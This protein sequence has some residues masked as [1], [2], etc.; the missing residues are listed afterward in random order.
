MIDQAEKIT[1]LNAVKGA[2]LSILVTLI[3]NYPRG[4]MPAELINWTGWGKNTISQGVSKLEAMALVWREN[5]QG[6][7]RLTDGVFQ[8]PLPL[9]LLGSGTAETSQKMGSS[10]LLLSSSSNRVEEEEE[11][12]EMAETSHF[13]GSLEGETSQKMGSPVDNFSGLPKKWE[14]KEWLM[15]G[16]VAPGSPKMRE[17]LAAGLDPQY[18][19]AHVLEQEFH[20]KM[21]QPHPASYLITS[22]SYGEPAPL[23]RCEACQDTLPC[24]CGI[25]HR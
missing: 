15:R 5:I 12:E 3:V 18:V 4:M 7:V 17:L 6:R 25:I 21:G 20:L 14:V 9:Y 19:K 22:L 13:L 16:G 2:P 1:F 23:M 11:E 24:Y 10:S 8:L